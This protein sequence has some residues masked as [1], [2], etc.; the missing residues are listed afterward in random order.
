MAKRNLGLVSD[1]EAAGARVLA[2]P[3]SQMVDARADEMRLR[4]RGAVG[5]HAVETVSV[6][7]GGVFVDGGVPHAVSGDADDAAFGEVDAVREGYV[8]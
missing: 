8:F 5:A 4:V 6:E 7:F 3:E 1:E 2:V